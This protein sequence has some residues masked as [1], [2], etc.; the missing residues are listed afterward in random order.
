MPGHQLRPERA[1]KSGGRTF[2][3]PPYFRDSAG[4]RDV[5]QEGHRAGAHGGTRAETCS[6]NRSGRP[7][8][9][10]TACAAVRTR[11]LRRSAHRSVTELKADARRWTSEWN[12]HP[13][14]SPRPRPSARSS[15]HSRPTVNE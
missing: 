1:D 5:A 6:A 2:L 3:G 10:H 15:A 11:K 12:K 7:A 13:G 9:G 8:S 4:P 14:H